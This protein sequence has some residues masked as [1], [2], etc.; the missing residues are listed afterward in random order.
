MAWPV[1]AGMIGSMAGGA[2][3]SYAG[4]QATQEAAQQQLSN[5][6]SEIAFQKWLADQNQARIKPFS[7]LGTS[8]LPELEQRRMGTFD[9][10]S[11]PY[12]SRRLDMLNSGMAGQMALRGGGNNAYGQRNALQNLTA[13]EEG[14]GYERALDRVRIGQGNAANAGQQYGQYANALSS[15]YQSAG[16]INSA[17]TNSLASQRSQLYGDVMNTAAGAPASMY[18]YNQRRNN[19]MADSGSRVFGSAPQAGSVPQ[20]QEYWGNTSYY[21]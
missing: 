3:S 1:I 8:A 2:A 11:S 19:R 21:D 18:L 7:D 16:N 9:T 17:L 6:R 5:T 13:D 4:Q 12:A 15:A 14:L 10:M 20:T